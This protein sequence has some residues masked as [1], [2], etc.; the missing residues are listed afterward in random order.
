MSREKLFTQRVKH[1]LRHPG[2]NMLFFSL[3]IFFFDKGEEGEESQQRQYSVEEEITQE[4][5][6]KLCT[7]LIRMCAVHV[8]LLCVRIFLSFLCMS[9]REIYRCVFMPDCLR[10]GHSL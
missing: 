9:V 2:T 1:I 8:T 3:S 7:M 5:G 10:G 4:T 6:G